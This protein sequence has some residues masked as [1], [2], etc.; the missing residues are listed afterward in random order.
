MLYPL[1]YERGR[2]QRP[3]AD[4]TTGA[5]TDSE[6]SIRSAVT[7]DIERDVDRDRDVDALTTGR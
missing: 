2:G 7:V 3:T 5:V 6:I 4:E 1:S